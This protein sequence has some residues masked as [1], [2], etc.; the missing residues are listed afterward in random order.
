MVLDLRETDFKAQAKEAS[1]CQMKLWEG[2]PLK[3]A[4]ISQKYNSTDPGTED[5]GKFTNKQV[6]MISSMRVEGV[7]KILRAN[8]RVYCRWAM[9]DV[10]ELI[11]TMRLV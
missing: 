7:D 10:E 2:R 11:C 4:D 1:F 5:K 6:Q 3:N 8:L 9:S